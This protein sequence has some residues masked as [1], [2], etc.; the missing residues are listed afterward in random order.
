MQQKKT[1][2]EHPFENDM[3]GR[4]WLGFL[5]RHPNLT[6]RSAQPLSYNRA[7]CAN[8]DTVNDYF[9]KLGATYA[10]LNILA[11]LMQIFN[12]DVSGVTVVHKPGKVITELGRKGKNTYIDMLCECCW[13]CAPTFS[14]I[15]TKENIRKAQRRMFT[16]DCVC[17]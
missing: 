4:A 15:P 5:E 14:H 16:T 1:G 9:A 10:R 2:K 7:V 8:T 6:L 13:V 3:A 11:K 17:M 12:V